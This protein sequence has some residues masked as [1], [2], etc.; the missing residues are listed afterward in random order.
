MVKHVVFDIDGTLIDTENAV[1]VALQDTILEVTNTKM[2][3]S[4]LKFALG[5]PG[6]VTL[7]KL[8]IKDVCKTNAIWNSYVKK[9][10]N[11]ITIFE[12]IS[13]VLK[14]LKEK[15][16]KLGIVTSKNRTEYKNDF[17]PF[18]LSHYFD[19]IICVEDT[20]L[21]KPSPD[22]ILK[23]IEYTGAREDEVLY[24]GDTI[25]DYQCAK[26]AGVAFGLA[27]WGCNSVKHIYATYFFSTPRDIIY[28]LNMGN[29]SLSDLPWL[30]LAMEIQFISQAG[31]TYSKNEFDRERFER[32]RELSAEILSLKTNNS[33]KYINDI[34]CKESGFQTPKLDTRAAIIH[35]DEILLVKES[36]GLWSLPGGWVDALES[37]KSNTIKEVKEEAGFDVLP[38]KLIA[39]QDRNKHNLPIY[40]FGVCKA[41][42]LC[43]IIGGKFE[44][45]IETEKSS[46][47]KVDDLPPLAIEKNTEEQIKMCFEAYNT[48]NWNVVFD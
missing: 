5:I 32:L 13:F 18:G 37:I 42:V 43:E 14:E 16:F 27:L 24:I 1:L 17:I 12:N 45:N 25:Y 6:E 31:L 38:V 36:S 11:T 15:G 33:A 30:K 40:F 21:P 34:F 44:I 3:L 7:N 47:W 9:Y 19:T 2:E 22:P 10:S 48:K 26:S 46:F 4:D 41:F 23:Y 8:G 39:I 20:A 35:D 28:T 29:T